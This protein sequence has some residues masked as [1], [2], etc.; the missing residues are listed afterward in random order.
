MSRRPRVV[1]GVLLLALGAG[2]GAACGTGQIGS[3]VEGSPGLA[4]NAASS[5]GSATPTSSASSGSTGAAAAA[6]STSGGSNAATTTS[7]AAAGGS[8]PALCTT[9]SVGVP[10]YQMVRRL[11]EDEYNA[12]LVDIF[13]Q[14]PTTWQTIQFVG[15]IKQA[16]EYDTYS[17]ALLVNQPWLAALVDSTFST[18]QALLAGPNASQ[19]FDPSCNAMAIDAACA[20]AM[21]QNYGYRL[22]RRPLTTAE[23]T[24][25]VNLFTQ[26]VSTVQLSPSDALAGTLAALMQSPNTLYIQEIGQPDGANFK[27]GGYELAS[28]L[29]YGL[30]GSAPS[31]ALLDSVGTGALETSEGIVAAS[32]TMIQS[33]GGQ[34]HLGKFFVEWTAYDSVPYAVKDPTVY[35]IPADIQTAMVQETQSLIQNI[36]QTGGGL[37]DLLLSPTTFVNQSLAQYY[38]WSTTGL[39]DTQ[40]TSVERPAGQGVGM[41]SQGGFLTIHATT[42]SSSPTQR[43]LFVLESLLCDQVPPPPPNIPVIPTPSGNVTTRERYE[44]QHAVGSCQA[45]H[46]QM[47]PIGFGLENFDGIGHYR[48]TEAG[49][50]IDASGTIEA[51]SSEMFNG[52]SDLAAKLEAAP[53]VSQ[54]FAAQLTA[55]V[56][57]VA[58]SDALCIAPPSSYTAANGA[59]S[60]SQVL[61][62]VV[63]PSHLVLRSP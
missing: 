3:G 36:T 8:R 7:T 62:Q 13:G 1:A 29:A 58:V 52:P 47:D 59:L 63:E 25:Y 19:L 55:Y 37:S 60:F 56:L 12:S 32:Q 48:T 27:L 23:V 5:T 30:T 53:Q 46:G 17:D 18:A 50:A 42:N 2:A 39:T 9:S 35:T 43:G 40:F 34:A 44:D 61:G 26:G 6:S 45:C 57:G 14:D 21:V 49:Q 4:S 51:L 22:F 10:A 15:D 16:N 11:S 28:I 54:C 24:N 38:G 20:Q 41:L 31:K 33:P